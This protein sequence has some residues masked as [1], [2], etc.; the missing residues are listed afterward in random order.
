MTAQTPKYKL[1]YPVDS[2][3]IRALPD[4]LKAQAESIETAL[5]AF[6]YSGADPSQVL[7]RV[8]S[9]EQI[10]ANL[11]T[12]APRVANYSTTT[13]RTMSKTAFTVLGGLSPVLTATEVVAYGNGKFTFLY[14]CVATICISASISPRHSGWAQPARHFIGIVKNYS[15]S[16]SPA[17]N[18]ELSRAAFMNEDL[19][20]MN[21]AG[22][23]SAGD[24]ITPVA[25]TTETG[26]SMTRVTASLIVQRVAQ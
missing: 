25:Y 20:S 1:V 4:I 19:A 15:G 18:D 2:D 12:N 11:D 23:F 21:Y 14:D 8:A 26:R 3:N 6:D 7:S 24:S 16:G 9:L 17:V 22:Y 10:T 5:A 13:A